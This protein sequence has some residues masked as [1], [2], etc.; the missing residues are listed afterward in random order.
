MLRG[1]L[2]F[3][4]LGL[5]SFICNGQPPIEIPANPDCGQGYVLCT[6]QSYLVAASPGAG[7]ITDELQDAPCLAITGE[8]GVSWL[9]FT[10]ATSSVLEFTLTPTNPND[11]LDFAVY[12]VTDPSDPCGSR[13]LLRCVSSGDVSGASPCMGDT[14][15]GNNATDISEDPGC[16][17]PQDGWV[18]PVNVQAGTTYLIAVNNYTGSASGYLLDFTSPGGDSDFDFVTPSID[19]FSSTESICAGE[20]IAFNATQMPNNGL[21]DVQWQF[22]NGDTTIIST[23]GSPNV[24]FPL[25]GEY[26]VLLTA[27]N[28]S[29]CS[30][31]DDS[32]AITVNSAPTM[33]FEV[34]APSCPGA[35]D[36][37]IITSFLGDGPFDFTTSGIDLE[38]ISGPYEV[39]G[40]E[41]GDT[42]SFELTSA[43]G[44]I[45]ED[46]V[47]LPG[48]GISFEITALPQDTSVYQNAPVLIFAT[49]NEPNMTY[50]WQTVNGAIIGTGQQTVTLSETTTII[51]TGVSDAGC[52]DTD[53]LTIEVVPVYIKIP[54]VFTPNGDNVNDMFQPVAEGIILTRF[55]VFDRWGELVHFDWTNAWDGTL[56]DLEMPSDIYYY[57]IDAAYPDGRVEILYGDF[58]LLR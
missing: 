13:I 35:A 44:C 3:A 15:L 19:A 50:S 28:G 56:N 5:C 57:F 26:Q 20:G 22:T 37:A 33:S 25:P 23:I 48:D 41:G 39:S 49:A 1:H 8:I 17:A 38:N 2:L 12:E 53:S 10:A 9:S 31:T 21:F 46:Q 4:L 29:G 32:L 45:A 58:L 54:T 40:L 42:Y 18:A 27:T 52:I 6:N 36:G 30:L 24:F 47:T 55:D 7:S 51:V 34:I 43:L 16:A 14:G 11:D